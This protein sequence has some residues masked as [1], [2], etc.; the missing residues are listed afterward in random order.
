MWV[1]YYLSRA[2]LKAHWWPGKPACARETTVC[3]EVRFPNNQNNWVSIIMIKTSESQVEIKVYIFYCWEVASSPDY[4]I[5]FD[6]DC[7]QNWLSSTSSSSNWLSP[8]PVWLTT[9]KKTTWASS[10][11]REVVQV[12]FYGIFIIIIKIIVFASAVI[13]RERM[14]ALSTYFLLALLLGKFY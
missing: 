10:W 12:N 14:K 8:A 1:Q 9:R 13:R 7:H 6:Y 4:Q 5:D 3:L 2:W 11:K